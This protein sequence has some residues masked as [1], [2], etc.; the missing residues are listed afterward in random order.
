MYIHMYIY[1]YVYI[2]MY[3]YIYIHNAYFLA[4]IVCFQR[5]YFVWYWYSPTT[6]ITRNLIG[7]KIVDHSGVDGASPVGAA[8]QLDLH[9]RLNAWLYWIG[10]KQLQDEARIILVGWFGASYIIDFTV[11]ISFKKCRHELPVY[12]L[13]LLPLFFPSKRQ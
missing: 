5:P 1:M 3:I 9:S 2:Y 12:I 7:S 6:D 11:C 10:Q 13:S 8:L 4:G